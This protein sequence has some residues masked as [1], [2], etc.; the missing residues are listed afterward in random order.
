MERMSGLPCVG[1]RGFIGGLAAAAAC[2]ALAD[3]EKPVANFMKTLNEHFTSPNL[4][5]TGILVPILL[6]KQAV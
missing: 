4:A 3:G 1:R 5:Y 6:D 2:P